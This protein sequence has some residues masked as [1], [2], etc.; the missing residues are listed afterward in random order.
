ML[1]NFFNKTTKVIENYYRRRKFINFNKKIFQQNNKKND[2]GI[3]LV[4]FN[5]FHDAHAI[6][7]IFKNYIKKK[8]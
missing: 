7:F 4:E 1:S 8:I 2:R 3:F 6:Y 5:A